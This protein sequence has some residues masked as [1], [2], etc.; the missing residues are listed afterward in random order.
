[1]IGKVIVC[2]LLA[3]AVSHGEQG[4]PQQPVLQ[5]YG[6]DWL[7]VRIPNASEQR[8][9]ILGSSEKP[10]VL[11]TAIVD[12]RLVVY[13]LRIDLVF[14]DVPPGPFPGPQPNPNPNPNPHPEPQPGPQPQPQPV[15]PFLVVI[16]EESDQRD[17]L[18][19]ETVRALT[20]V[21]IREY[22][23][24]HQSEF[25]L[26]DKDATTDNQ[27]IKTVIAEAIKQSLPRLIIR[28][29]EG[30]IVVNEAVTSEQAAMDAIRRVIR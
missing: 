26:I 9:L 4:L 18:P 13:S 29:S 2:A 15:G 20:S 19:S 27:A 24:Q 6:T 30:R 16:V 21:A 22:V 5:W 25:L 23:K 14:E 12:G 11:V 10:V 17:T 28:D 8:W 7:M 3:L 1:M